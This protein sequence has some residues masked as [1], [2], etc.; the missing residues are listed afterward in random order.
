[1]NE[2]EWYNVVYT[3]IKC[4]YNNKVNINQIFIKIKSIIRPNKFN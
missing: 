3:Y 4:K 1:M 2:N